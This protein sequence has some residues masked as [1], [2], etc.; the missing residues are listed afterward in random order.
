MRFAFVLYQRNNRKSTHA[1][2][3]RGG[4]DNL[5]QGTAKHDNMVNCHFLLSTKSIRSFCSATS[6]TGHTYPL[7]VH[8]T[9]S[10]TCT[11]SHARAHSP[12]VQARRH[13]MHSSHSHACTATLPRVSHGTHSHV[14]ASNTG[15]TRTTH[16]HACSSRALHAQ[17]HTPSHASAR[18]TPTRESSGTTRSAH[19]HTCASAR[20]QHAR[21]IFSHMLAHRY[22]TYSMHAYYFVQFV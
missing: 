21:P 2:T 3:K 1:I 7:P 8:C 4:N 18:H 17:V 6:C 5:T 14:H 20:I 10:R 19:I 16:S 9:L 13:H 15:T 11:G 12:L 22:H